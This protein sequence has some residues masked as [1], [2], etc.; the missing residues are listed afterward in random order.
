[1]VQPHRPLTSPRTTITLAAQLKRLHR[2][3][4]RL[5]ALTVN[6][7]IYQ[8]TRAV[9]HA[10][11]IGVC[12]RQ[13]HPANIMIQFPTLR[14][15]LT[16][17]DAELSPSSSPYSAPELFLSPESVIMEH[18]KADVWSLGM[19]LIE[20]LK[21]SPLVKTDPE[22]AIEPS[23]VIAQMMK[24][25][26]TPSDSALAILDPTSGSSASIVRRIPPKPWTH[27]LPR[28]SLGG[29]LTH[30]LDRMHDWNPATREP[31]VSLLCFEYFR[32]TRTTSSTFRSASSALRRCAC[33]CMALHYWDRRCGGPQGCHIARAY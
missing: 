28:M 24:T 21:G 31:A 27:V 23:V 13:V 29:K 33:A 7:I 25:F 5:P 8:L 1:M 15:Q 32:P 2:L 16:G 14:A 20:A 9:A 12:H 10:A 3:R 30:L 19:V 18:M 17:W 4:K 26:G 11:G 22:H 6:A